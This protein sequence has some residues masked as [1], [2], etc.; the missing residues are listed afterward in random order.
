MGI[1]V[2]EFIGKLSLNVSQAVA[3]IK[4]TGTR[5][6]GLKEKVSGL[7]SPLIKLGVAF[8]GVFAVHEVIEMADATT[9]L[10]T[11]AEAIGFAATDVF[12]LGDAFSFAGAT[13]QS[14]ITAG[15]T[16]NQTI[17]FLSSGA[18]RPKA[19]EM[20]DKTLKVLGLNLKDLAKQDPKKQFFA[21]AEAMQR[22]KNPQQAFAAGQRLL[23]TEM[24]TVLQSAIAQGKSIKDIAKSLT[25][26]GV[27]TAG[28]IEGAKRIQAAWDDITDI[29]DKTELTGLAGLAL[30][31]MFEYL[32]TLVNNN[33]QAFQDWAENLARSVGNVIRDI[34]AGV[35]VII[36]VISTVGEYLSS[37]ASMIGANAA[38][39]TLA[40]R[41]I[42]ASVAVLIASFSP[43]TG[44]IMLAVIAFQ[45]L[46]EAAGGWHVGFLR[47]VRVVEEEFADLLSSLG[48]VA[49]ALGMKDLAKS[50]FSTSGDLLAAA[51]SAQ[52]DIVK[53]TAKNESKPDALSPHAGASA[54]P[55]KGAVM[56]TNNVKNSKNN[57]NIYVSVDKTHSPEAVA[58]QLKRE[59]SIL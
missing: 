53:L 16:L 27:V 17:G 19:L 49:S 18:A 28:A 41:L 50:A 35:K 4:E 6:N 39:T 38:T 44:T 29:V 46:G 15:Q 11:N 45:A 13:A 52:G 32:A 30:A 8:A 55:F 14:F 23:G 47:A 25:E 59:L 22:A 3:G 21:I 5:L 58:R 9:K 57:V 34:V 56:N 20:F 42:A 40:I 1:N 48:K 37:F 43:I 26:Y 31:P 2:E 54:Q 7:G 36:D 10:A 33:K 24:A 12:N 51:S